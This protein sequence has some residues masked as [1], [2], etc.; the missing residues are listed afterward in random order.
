M[1]S[2]NAAP[3][4]DLDDVQPAF[5]L[6]RPRPPA[7]A[8]VGPLAD[9]GRAGPAADA[10]IALVVQR[11]VGDAVVEDETPHVALRPRQQRV[12]LHQGKL[13]VPLNDA[14]DRPVP[15]LVAAD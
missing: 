8:F 15:R 5:L 3:I 11:V 13:L 2:L 14:S 9:G 4:P 6:R 10:R 12:D 1:P 7:G